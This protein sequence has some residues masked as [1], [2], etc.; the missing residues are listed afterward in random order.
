MPSDNITY[1]KLCSHLVMQ[2][3]SGCFESMSITA[4]QMCYAN[5]H[6]VVRTV[7]STSR[8]G[9]ISQCFPPVWFGLLQQL[10]QDDPSWVRFFLGQ[11]LFGVEV[12]HCWDALKTFLK[13]KEHKETMSLAFED[14]NTC[15]ITASRFRISGAMLLG[16]GDANFQWNH[17]LGNGRFSLRF[18]PLD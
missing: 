7:I 11:S 9:K 3:F 18:A 16:R 8:T 1:L 6:W 14:N 17:S 13:A 15:P 5:T 10:P 4:S 2:C 12:Q